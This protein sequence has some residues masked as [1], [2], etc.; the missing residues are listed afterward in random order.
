MDSV[1]CGYPSYSSVRQFRIVDSADEVHRR[2]VAR[3]TF[4]DLDDAELERI[5]RSGDPNGQNSD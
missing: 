4:D 3:H 1:V 5:T 2:I